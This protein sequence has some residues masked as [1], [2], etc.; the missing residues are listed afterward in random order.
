MTC[1]QLRDFG[2]GGDL[3]LE[4]WLLLEGECEGISAGWDFFLGEED[5]C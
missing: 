2:L 3:A 4:G 5:F 1:D